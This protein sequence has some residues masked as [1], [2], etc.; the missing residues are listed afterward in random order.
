MQKTIIL[1]ILVYDRIKEAGRTQEVLSK[2]ADVIRTRLG[3]H[4]LSE[5]VCSRVGTIVLVLQGDPAKWE[6]LETE[7]A[8]IGGVEVKKISFDYMFK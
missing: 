3:F 7:L 2:H 5:T 6:Q 4:E 1:G 8:E